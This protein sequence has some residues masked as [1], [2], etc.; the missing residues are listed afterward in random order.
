M[1]FA[2]I[3]LWVA[4]F[5]LNIVPVAAFDT[6]DGLALLLGLVLGQYVHNM[7]KFN[8]YIPNKVISWWGLQQT[9]C[10]NLH[11]H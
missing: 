7:Y 1:E 4:V 2:D 5:C 9:Q 3:F 11:S 8:L 6:G 10:S